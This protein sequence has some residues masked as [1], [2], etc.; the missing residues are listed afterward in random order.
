MT[1][2]VSSRSWSTLLGGSAFLLGALLVWLAP[3]PTWADWVAGLLLFLSAGM[4]YRLL[5]PAH[6]TLTVDGQGIRWSTDG[7]SQADIPWGEI[8]HLRQS[9]DDDTFRM[10]VGKALEVHL[11][12][13]FLRSPQARQEFLALVAKARPD[14]SIERL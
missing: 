8:R 1:E 11:P 10:D 3:A 14:I 2:T 13:Q 5:V 6:L 9:R 7:R 12:M 4:I